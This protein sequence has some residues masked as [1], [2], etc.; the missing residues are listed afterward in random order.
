MT[1]D[2]RAHTDGDY[3]GFFMT[4][5]LGLL[6]D[7]QISSYSPEGIEHLRAAREAFSREFRQ[8]HPDQ[9]APN[10]N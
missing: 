7:A 4:G 3:Y 9:W 10:S 2:E 6:D 8:R 1:G 5:L